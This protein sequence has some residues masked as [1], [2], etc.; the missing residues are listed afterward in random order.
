M[1]KSNSYSKKWIDSLKNIKQKIDPGICEKMIR[2]L[3]LLEQLVI[4]KL[5]FVF[6]G[7]TSLILLIDAP[8]RFSIDIDINTKVSKEDLLRVL[9]SVNQTELFTKYNENKRKETGVPKAHFKF[10]YKSVVNKRE[11][12]II[13]DVLFHKYSY[14][15]IVRTP[16]K[17][18]WIDTDESNI[19]VTT[20]T[21]D[22][23]LGDKLT[24][25]APNTIGISYNTGKSMEIIKQLFD[26]GRLFDLAENFNI[27]TK[28]FYSILSEEIK[29]RKNT[30]SAEDVLKDI[31]NTSLLISQ[32]PMISKEKPEKARELLDGLKRFSVYPIGIKYRVDDS[33]VSSAKASYIASKILNKDKTPI[34]KYFKGIEIKTYNFHSKYNFLGKLKKRKLEAYFYWIQVFKSFKTTY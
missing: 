10:Y 14:P 2:A 5:D 23:I 17:S 13:L 32:F 26:V 16:I 30:I 9:E 15:K 6:K 25:F 3:G 34:L 33:I 7:G 4:N 22:S 11:N 27:V 24:A 18:F 1:I 31:I 12:F 21:I 8:Q 19:M 20:P 29:F 28:S